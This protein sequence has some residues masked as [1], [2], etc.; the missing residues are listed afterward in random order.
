MQSR[1]SIV[2]LSKMRGCEKSTS[3]GRKG[4]EPVAITNAS[5]VMCRVAEPGLSTSIVCGS[6]NLRCPE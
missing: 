3:A 4:R 1:S 5:A 2:S 6:R